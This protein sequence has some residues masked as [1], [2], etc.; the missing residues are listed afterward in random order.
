M[1]RSQ[2]KKKRNRRLPQRS[3][4]RTTKWQVGMINGTVY[5]ART[6]NKLTDIGAFIKQE[7][8]SITPQA[9]A[10]RFIKKTLPGLYMGWDYMDTGYTPGDIVSNPK[11]EKY[12][13]MSSLKKEQEN[14]KKLA[15]NT[16]FVILK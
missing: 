11:Y 5:V 12:P 13:R 14:S 9:A 15:K 16:E 8:R 7:I 2:H 10:R 3:P 1:G 4:D 6:G